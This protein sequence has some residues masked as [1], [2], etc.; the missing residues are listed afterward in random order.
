MV[1][2]SGRGSANNTYNYDGIHAQDNEYAVT[3]LLPPQDAIQEFKMQT[4]GRDATTGRTGGALVNLVTKQAVSKDAHGHGLPGRS[5]TA[6]AAA[7]T[8]LQR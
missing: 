1:G 6:T 5:T 3:I 7:T 2:L 4:S 8:I